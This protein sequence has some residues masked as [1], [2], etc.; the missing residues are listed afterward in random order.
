MA[1]KKLTL[2]D[3]I[4]EKEK[5]Q[6]KDDVTEELFIPRLDATIT[7]RKPER[8]LCLE[9]I[10]MGQQ[11]DKEGDVFLVYNTVVEPDLKDKELQQAFGCVDPT[12]VVLN[13]FESGE[14]VNIAQ[15]ALDLAGYSDSV[16]KV[17]DLKN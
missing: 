1:K 12:E 17:N 2:N 15:S 16:K 3:L 14:I 13:L 7:I 9:S 10:Q 11:D 5:Y 8:S 6:V 4:K